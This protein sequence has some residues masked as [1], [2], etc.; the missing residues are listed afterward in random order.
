MPTDA[1]NSKCR[2]IALQDALAKYYLDT[3]T[4]PE[5]I[6]LTKDFYAILEKDRMNTIGWLHP[7]GYLQ[8]ELRAYR[9]AKVYL[10]E[11]FEIENDFAFMTRPEFTYFKERQVMFYRLM[12]NGEWHAQGK[13]ADERKNALTEEAEGFAEMCSRYGAWRQMLKE[14]LELYPTPPQED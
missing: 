6:L 7:A 11:D 3:N 2:M 5:V 12:T 13:S 10:A 8:A 4:V 14:Y 9:G 1:Q